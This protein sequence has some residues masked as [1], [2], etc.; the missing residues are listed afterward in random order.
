MPCGFYVW[1]HS[2]TTVVKGQTFQDCASAITPS[3]FAM[4][5]FALA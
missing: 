3:T 1:N 2:T 5:S 4:L